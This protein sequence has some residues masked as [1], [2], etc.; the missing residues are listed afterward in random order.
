[1]FAPAP[2]HCVLVTFNPIMVD[3]HSALFS[4]MAVFRSRTE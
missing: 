1:M 4:C 3:I 2:G